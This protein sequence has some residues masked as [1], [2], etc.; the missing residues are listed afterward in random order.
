MS[1][2]IDRAFPFVFH[3]SAPENHAPAIVGRLQ[4]EP[5]IKS[6][7]GAA[8]KEMANLARADDNVDT[9]S[10][11]RTNGRIHAIEWSRQWSGL[12]VA[13]HSAGVSFFPNRKCRRQR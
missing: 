2:F 11:S 5:D 9:I 4:L 1:A 10:L 12:D 13:C 7:D 6:V 8:G 3:S